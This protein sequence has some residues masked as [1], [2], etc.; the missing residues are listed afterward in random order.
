M[1][2]TFKTDYK[3]MAKFMLI[4]M[5]NCVTQSNSL[6]GNYKV[7]FQAYAS[8]MT[9][10]LCHNNICIHTLYIFVHSKHTLHFLCLLFRNSRSEPDITYWVFKKFLSC[11]WIFNNHSW[12]IFKLLFLSFLLMGSNNKFWNYESTNH[13]NCF[14]QKNNNK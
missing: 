8:R 6:R 5:L 1:K 11:I 3:E 4:L 12:D 7:A 9:C 10:L 14:W 13:P 2:R